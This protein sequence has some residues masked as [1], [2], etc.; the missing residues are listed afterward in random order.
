MIGWEVK[1]A[2]VG[3]KR[4]GRSWL[5]RPGTEAR[6]RGWPCVLEQPVVAGRTLWGEGG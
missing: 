6:N 3:R 1:A 5:R 4:E 2:A